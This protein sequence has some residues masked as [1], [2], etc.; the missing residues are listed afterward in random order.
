MW[1][2]S[3]FLS[4]FL[5]LCNL[6]LI[7]CL[8]K[9][10]SSLESLGYNNNLI[11]PFIY[12]FMCPPFF[13]LL[14]NYSNLCVHH[15]L[16]LPFIYSFACLPYSFPLIYL[17][18]HVSNIFLFCNNSLHFNI[19]HVFIYLLIYLFMCKPIHP[20]HSFFY[21]LLKVLAANRP[22]WN[23]YINVSHIHDYLSIFIHGKHEYKVDL[24]HYSV[25]FK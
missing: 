25:N 11:L 5:A 13:I 24:G 20:I 8:P 2:F 21:L 18:I 9:I 22:F 1:F 19:L 16:I 17:F 14:N 10:Q 7:H 6:Y 12:P 3:S 4:L 23:Y 15:L